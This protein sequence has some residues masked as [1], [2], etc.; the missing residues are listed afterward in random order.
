MKKVMEF[1]DKHLIRSVEDKHYSFELKDNGHYKVFGHWTYP[2]IDY[3]SENDRWNEHAKNEPT[4]KTWKSKDV[5]SVSI[6]N[7][8][9]NIKAI[10]INGK[11]VSKYGYLQTY[12]HIPRT[13]PDI[14]G[15]YARSTEDEVIKYI[16]SYLSLL[17]RKEKLK[18][19]N[20]KK[21]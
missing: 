1:L 16:N 9:L 13:G 8:T 12:A 10:I 2:K 17:Q 6:N 11:S 19:I 14:Y 20:E 21:Y 15:Y 7:E 4:M 3:K 18:V 5:I